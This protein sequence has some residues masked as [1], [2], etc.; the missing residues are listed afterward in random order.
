[1]TCAAGVT[2]SE[3]ALVRVLSSLQLALLH[4]R[5]QQSRSSLPT[6]CLST[7]A[8][9]HEQS[10]LQNVAVVSCCSHSSHLCLFPGRS[11]PAGDPAACPRT[12]DGQT[13]R[14]VGPQ[15]SGKCSRC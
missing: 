7:K 1:M 4:R 15:T 13:R 3:Y 11:V 5:F 9:S 6:K 10:S 8:T 2:H 14:K 12:F